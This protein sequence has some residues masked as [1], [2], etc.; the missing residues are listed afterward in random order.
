MR[1][2]FGGLGFFG[3]GWFRCGG[4]RLTAGID[5]IPADGM[6]LESAVWGQFVR[7]CLAGDGVDR[8]GREESRSEFREVGRI[9]LVSDVELFEGAGGDGVLSGSGG[10]SGFQVDGFDRGKEET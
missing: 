4:G 3:E 9:L 1:G 7:R 8:D 6:D 10:E 2:A 5:F